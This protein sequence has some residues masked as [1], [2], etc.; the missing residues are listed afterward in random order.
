[1]ILCIFP[2]IFSCMSIGIKTEL[3]LT[4]VRVFLW[5]DFKAEGGQD[6]WDCIQQRKD[7]GWPSSLEKDL[8]VFV[9]KYIYMCVCIHTYID[10]FIIIISVCICMYIYNIHVYIHQMYIF[11]SFSVPNCQ[12]NK[13]LVHAKRHEKERMSGLFVG[14]WDIPERLFKHIWR[15]FSK[16]IGWTHPYPPFSLPLSTA[17]PQAIRG[18]ICMLIHTAGGLWWFEPLCGGLN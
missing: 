9:F 18:W 17:H 13:L 1:M 2:A 6:I 3:H 8:T 10:N 11:Q 7:A 16:E 14:L 15:E 4:K 12:L 5:E